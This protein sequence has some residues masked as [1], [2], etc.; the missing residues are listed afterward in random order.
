MLYSL[1]ELLKKG[2]SK[3]DC[4]LALEGVFGESSRGRVRFNLDDLSEDDAGM[5][6]L[7]GTEGEFNNL[8]VLGQVACICD[9]DVVAMM[10]HSKAADARDNISSIIAPFTSA[11]RPK[12]IWLFT[13]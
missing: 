9:F 3:H 11:H 5:P 7:F 8:R 1:K 12:D 10:S 6:T 4:Q 2:V 13:S